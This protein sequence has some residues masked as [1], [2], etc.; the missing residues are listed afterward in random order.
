[1]DLKKTI[2]KIQVQG[3]KL[4]INKKNDTRKWKIPLIQDI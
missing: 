3:I 4:K 1:M 2:M